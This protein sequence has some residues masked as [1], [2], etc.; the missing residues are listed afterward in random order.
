M[1]SRKQ[2]RRR[3]KDRR[4]EYEYVYVDADGRE[5]EV[6]PDEAEA[7]APKPVTK[8]EPKR[9]DGKAAASR[10]S[11][12]RRQV[13]PPSW[14]RSFRRA[15]IFAPFMFIT[16]FLLDRNAALAVKLLVTAQ[17]LVF[18]IPF[19]YLID[20]IMYRRFAGGGGNAARGS[21][22]A[23]GA[24]RATPPTRGRRTATKG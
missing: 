21:G 18:F 14:R 9:S 11:A 22:S 19:T 8:S 2:R 23:R 6:D 3:E 5:V 10:G 7:E 1:P 24:G 20:R 16:L 12:H 15:A 17:M 4:H 13:E